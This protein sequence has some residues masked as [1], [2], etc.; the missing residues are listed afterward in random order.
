MS[1]VEDKMKALEQRI[2]QQCRDDYRRDRCENT[3]P[4]GSYEHM[5]Y[6]SEHQRIEFADLMG[7]AW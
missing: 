4:K 6:L 7:G 3:Y 5:I 1:T 2:R